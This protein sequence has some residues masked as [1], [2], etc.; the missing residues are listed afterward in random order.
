M[1]PS[2]KSPSPPSSMNKPNWLA[3]FGV[4]SFR[5]QWPSDLTTSWAFEMETL[6]LGWYI[7]IKSES[8]ILLVIF[9]ALQYFGALVS[10]L[11][12][13]AG[14]RMGYRRML[15]VTRAIYAFL[16]GTLLVLGWLDALNPYIVLFIAGI[17][18]MIRPSDMVFRYAL[19]AQTQ[20]PHLLMGALGVSRITSDSA[21]MAG[22]L[23]GA[24]AVAYLG[25][26]A[27]YVVITLLYMCSFLL[28]FQVNDHFVPDPHKVPATPLQDLRE[29]FVYISDKPIL[30]GALGVAFLAN[31]LGFPLFLGLLP[32]V[33]KN[34]YETDQTGLGFLGAS[35]AFGG[36]LASIV[37]SSNR[38]KL[39]ASQTMI[40]AACSWFLIDLVFAQVNH[41]IL[42]MVLL[43][44]AGFAQSLCLTPLAAVML[45]GTE[46]AYRGRVMGMRILAIWGLTLGLLVSGPLINA[47]GFSVTASIYSL[48]GLLL[49]IGMTVYWRV[50]LW[51]ASSP[52][53][54]HM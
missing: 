13:V 25:M 24:G 42:G 19:I 31:F 40:I 30:L 6:I 21:R 20:P 4:K 44:G 49:T 38:F 48:S 10:P 45:R 17:V 15:W 51:Q 3:P 12:G 5:F 36:L 46:Q 54:T 34:I 9:G 29:A 43:V 8:V 26:T 23:A 14:D 47:Y 18:G 11:F 50:H 16:A 41:I 35:F 39:R 52:A 33:A 32:Y 53:N 7:L 1:Q 37:L 28:A 22:A 27:A 2:I